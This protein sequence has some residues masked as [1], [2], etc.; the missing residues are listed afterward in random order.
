VEISFLVAGSATNPYEVTFAK[1]SDGLSVSCTCPAG[2]RGLHC[3]HRLAIITGDASAVVS[4]NLAELEVVRTWL[5]G[6]DLEIACSEFREAEKNVEDAKTR[7]DKVKK[8]IGKLM[9]G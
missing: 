4:K 1:K 5:A 7:F 6:S 8:R 9:A 3:K 2:E